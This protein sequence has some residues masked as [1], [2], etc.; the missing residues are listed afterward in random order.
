MEPRSRDRGNTSILDS[1][2][3]NIRLQWSR[4]HVIAE[5]FLSPPQ[6]PPSCPLQW[7]RDHV[8]AEIVTE[9][10]LGPVAVELQWSRDHVIAEISLFTAQEPV[11]TQASMEPRSRDRGNLMG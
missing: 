7:S 5:M 6:T 8:I 2:T 3:D 1:G 4:D 10:N 11:P 9:L